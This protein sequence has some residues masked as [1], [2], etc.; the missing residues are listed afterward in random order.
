MWIFV[1]T[2]T[3]KI[4][5]LAKHLVRLTT[6]NNQ[7][8]SDIPLEQQM[9]ISV[10]SK[11]REDSARRQDTWQSPLFLWCIARED[12]KCEAHDV[13]DASN[14]CDIK[15]NWTSLEPGRGTSKVHALSQK[16][17][18]RRGVKLMSAWRKLSTNSA[19]TRERDKNAAHSLG[20]ESQASEYMDCEACDSD[21]DFMSE[22]ESEYSDEASG[23]DMDQWMR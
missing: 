10:E 15:W 20:W 22:L 1:K 11:G 6:S 5:T 21:E 7:D 18:F 13:G 4:F 8:K 2:R 16:I 14:I 17:L 3:G 9:C 12:S 23:M 19:A